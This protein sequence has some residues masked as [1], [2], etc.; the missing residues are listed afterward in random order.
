[1]ASRITWHDLCV[2]CCSFPRARKCLF[3]ATV[4][5][6]SILLALSVSFTLSSI[7]IFILSWCI[8]LSLSLFLTDALCLGDSC[9]RGVDKVALTTGPSKIALEW[10]IHTEKDRSSSSS[11]FGRCFF[12]SFP[13][14]S[15]FMHMET[16]KMLSVTI[17]SSSTCTFHWPSC[18]R[19]IRGEAEREKGKKETERSRLHFSLCL[20]IDC[21]VLFD[22]FPG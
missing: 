6:L 17:L 5:F 15:V 21:Q 13:P 16:V 18:H 14:V 19:W 3:L 20:V 12:V 4:Y 10:N 2:L 9:S 8:S 1:M 22:L 7:F 11:Y